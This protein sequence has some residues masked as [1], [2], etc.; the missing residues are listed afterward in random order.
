MPN[1]LS[2]REAESCNQPYPAGRFCAYTDQ[3]AHSDKIELASDGASTP[4]I[5][6]RRYS[7]TQRFELFSLIVH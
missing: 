2:C 5:G 3:R 4:E 6:W 1:A 7:A